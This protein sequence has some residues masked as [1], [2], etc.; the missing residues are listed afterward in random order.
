MAESVR[1]RAWEEFVRAIIYPPERS[2]LIKQELLRR[3]VKEGRNPWPGQLVEI[4]REFSVSRQRVHQL[5]REVRAAVERHRVEEK[6][7]AD[8]RERAARR[9]GVIRH[10]RGRR[11]RHARNR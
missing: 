8:R 9:R 1:E 6:K 11:V 10:R 4:A 5:W 7:E 3:F 2:V